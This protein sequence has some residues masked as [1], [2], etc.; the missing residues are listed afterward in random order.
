V[1]AAAQLSAGGELV[2]EHLHRNRAQGLSSTSSML[3]SSPVKQICSYAG[4]A[5]CYPDAAR[6]GIQLNREGCDSTAQGNKGSD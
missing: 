6:L 1:A 5:Q 3:D 4:C 2:G